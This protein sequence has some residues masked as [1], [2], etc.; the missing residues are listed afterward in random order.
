MRFLQV[1]EIDSLQASGNYI[2]LHTPKG[3]QVIRD[4]M[5]RMEARLDPL[6]FIRIHRSTIV[7]IQKVR[8]IEPHLHGDYYVRMHDGRRLTLSRNYRDKFRGKFG[9]EF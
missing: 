2:H 7:N 1:E 6:R 8:E 5:S 9:P 3:V 4:T